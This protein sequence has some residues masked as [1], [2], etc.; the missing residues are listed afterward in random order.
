M[1]SHTDR[2]NLDVALKEFE[3]ENGPANAN[4]EDD[5]EAKVKR[6]QQFRYYS[7]SR[8]YSLQWGNCIS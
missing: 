6:S 5:D 8:I 3:A 2:Y 7:G 1:N 4:S